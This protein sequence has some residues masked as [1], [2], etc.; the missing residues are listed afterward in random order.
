MSVK[1]VE[2]YPGSWY[3][4]VVYKHFRKTKQIGSKDGTCGRGQP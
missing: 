3:I 2:M 1:V 4:R